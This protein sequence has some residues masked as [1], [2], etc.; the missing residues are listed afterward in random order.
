MLEENKSNAS[1]KKILICDDDK[2]V[3][4]FLQRFLKREGYSNVDMVLTGEEALAKISEGQRY[5]LVL[6]DIRLPGIDGIQ[7]LQRIKEADDKITVIMITGFPEIETAEQAVKLGAYDYIVKPFDLAYLKL[8][9][10]SK[11]LLKP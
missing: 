11:M 3:T 2:S 1:N 8:V 10:L 6:L 4:D 9:F 7:T 5:D